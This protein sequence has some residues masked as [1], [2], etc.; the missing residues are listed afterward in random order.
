MIFKCWSWLSEAFL[1]QTWLVPPVA[2]AAAKGSWLVPV[3]ILHKATERSLSTT[4]LTLTPCSKSLEFLGFLSIFH[5][6]LPNP[7]AA[8][9]CSMISPYC[10]DI[11]HPDLLQLSVLSFLQ[12]EWFFLASES[13]IVPF[14]EQYAW[15]K[16]LFYTVFLVFFVCFFEENALMC[17]KRHPPSSVS[18]S[19]SSL[20]RQ[21]LSWF[22]LPL[23]G[24]HFAWDLA[25][26]RFC[27]VN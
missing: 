13:W 9:F 25:Q 15:R 19:S 14:L 8:F 27:L 20:W 11:T 10:M 5:K 18:P 21:D 22:S 17:P 6:V 3:S 24:Q 16:R 7:I 2:G 26:Q 4:G 1:I 23:Y 12:T